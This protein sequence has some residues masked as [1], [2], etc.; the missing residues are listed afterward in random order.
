MSLRRLV[1][2]LLASAALLAG[3]DR[4]DPAT[5]AGEALTPAPTAPADTLP[6]APG[7]ETFGAEA[8]AA[9]APPLLPPAGR[10]NWAWPRPGERPNL[11]TRAGETTLVGLDGLSAKPSQ[12]S[13]L[14]ARGIYTVCRMNL[15]TLDPHSP[16]A[17]RFTA[18]MRLREA[19]GQPILAFDPANAVRPGSALGALLVGRLNVCVI[20]GFD[21]VDPGD[22]GSAGGAEGDSARQQRLNFSGWLADQAHAAGLA[23][24]QHGALRD[25]EERDRHGRVLADIFDGAISGGCRAEGTCAALSAYVSR[26]KLALDLG[27]SERPGTGPDCQLAERLGINRLETRSRPASADSCTP[28]R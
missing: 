3:C 1:P 4:D 9:S 26:G 23:I 11:D 27:D 24:F 17:A 12:V 10:V 21:A 5:P 25:A 18:P 15:T 28:E 7:S 14:K 2:A 22:L 8:P 6:S 13:A 16:D 19:G 20:R